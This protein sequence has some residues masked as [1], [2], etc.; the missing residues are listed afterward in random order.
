MGDH[1]SR[2]IGGFG[3]RF[4]DLGQATYN[5]RHRRRI[6]IETV[7]IKWCRGLF[8]LIE[9]PRRVVVRLEQQTQKHQPHVNHA[10]LDIEILEFIWVDA[11][12]KLC[13]R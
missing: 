9:I 6:F 10:L 4:P 5:S 3:N 2:D 13:C 7:V 11:Q 1:L 12:P 8:A